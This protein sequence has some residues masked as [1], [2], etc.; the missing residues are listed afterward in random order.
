MMSN[1]VGD[2]KTID[3]AKKLPPGSTQSYIDWDAV[4]NLPE[5]YEAVISRVEFDP[6]KDFSEVGNKNLMP[7]PN[8]LYKIAEACGISGYRDSNTAPVYQEVNVNE[9]ERKDGYQMVK[10]HVGYESI[11]TSHVLTEDGTPRDSSPCTAQYNAWDRAMVLWTKEEKYT[12]GY[13]KEGKYPA[14]YKSK[15][16]RKAHFA[17]LMKFALK[18]AETQAYGKTIRELAGLKTGYKEDEIKSGLMIFSRIRISKTMLKLKA[19]AELTAIER[20]GN[21]QMISAPNSNLLF[22]Q[23]Q[24]PEPTE[25]TTEKEITADHEII[26]DIETAD[27]LR[28]KLVNLGESCED[29]DKL[30]HIIEWLEAGPDLAKDKTLV[31]FNSAI[32]FYEDHKDDSAGQGGPD[33]FEEEI[34]F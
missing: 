28:E 9:M 15:Y 33:D 34:L 5:Q 13:T 6:K 2:K 21:Q 29:L 26:E 4:D 14:K 24:L 20:G 25:P 22:E 7:N 3:Y 19:A 23:E 1:I 18:I 32:K 16:D 12:E 10:I 17:D 11:K 30:E 27:S 8:I 31:K